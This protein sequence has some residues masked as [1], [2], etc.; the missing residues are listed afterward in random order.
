MKKVKSAKK[1]F[2]AMAA[3]AISATVIGG[4]VSFI[5]RGNP[6]VADA[7]GE[8]KTVVVDT[9]LG[10]TRTQTGN[11]YY[12]GPDASGFGNAAGTIDDQIGRAHV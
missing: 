6:E 1:V 9:A 12:A 4:A 2:S 8:R 5:E 7:V 3:L 10:Q 11:V